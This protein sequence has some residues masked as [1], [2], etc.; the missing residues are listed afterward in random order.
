MTYTVRWENRALGTVGWRGEFGDAEAAYQYQQSQI[1]RSQPFM[2]F[3]VWLG[4][5]HNPIR[6]V[7]LDN[8]KNS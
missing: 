8:V 7:D 4:T 3:E 2:R 6:E 5:P 1:Q